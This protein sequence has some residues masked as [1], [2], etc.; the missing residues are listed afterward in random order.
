MNDVLQEA[1]EEGVKLAFE[2]YAKEAGLKDVASKVW[3]A[4]KQEGRNFKEVWKPQIEGLKSIGRKKKPRGKKTFRRPGVDPRYTE[5]GG[6]K[7]LR[8]I[9]GKK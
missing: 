9:F 8:K 4:A 3:G 5:P 7:E 1:Y 6:E 2:E